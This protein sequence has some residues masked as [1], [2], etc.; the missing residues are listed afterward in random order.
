MLSL[1]FL[2]DFLLYRNVQ[3]LTKS[4]QKKKKKKP[5]KKSIDERKSHHGFS[6]NIPRDSRERLSHWQKHS[7]L[8]LDPLP[9]WW[10][11]SKWKITQT[12]ENSTTNL[13]P[14]YSLQ[15]HLTQE[16]N[17]EREMREYQIEREIGDEEAMLQKSHRDEGSC[18]DENVKPERLVM[19]KPQR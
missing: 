1:Q 19:R 11:F 7:S 9:I 2:L 14:R 10:F 13:K 4:I 5:R 18:R 17:K 6:T 3:N 8:I 15:W 12:L 16:Q